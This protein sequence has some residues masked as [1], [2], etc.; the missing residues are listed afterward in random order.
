MH[1]KYLH[2]KAETIKCLEKN[3]EGNLHNLGKI[4]ISWQDTCAENDQK[5]KAD[6]LDSI[7]M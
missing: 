6:K 4:M 2:V 7:K 3:I 5:R 1:R